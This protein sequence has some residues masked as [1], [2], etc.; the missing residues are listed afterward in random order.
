MKRVVKWHDEA[1]KLKLQHVKP[2]AV[3]GTLVTDRNQDRSQAQ[4][5][6]TASRKLSGDAFCFPDW[7]CS[8]PEL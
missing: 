2:R 6:T 4:R 3:E 8:K 7:A 5:I 1:T